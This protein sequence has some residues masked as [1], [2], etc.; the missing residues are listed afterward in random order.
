MTSAAARSE[1][2]GA[3]MTSAAAG[4]EARVHNDFSSS[5]EWGKR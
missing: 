1:A 3:P 2:R 5:K 4:S